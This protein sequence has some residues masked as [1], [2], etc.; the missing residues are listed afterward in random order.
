MRL[1]CHYRPSYSTP[2]S[3]SGEPFSMS[4]SSP[5]AQDQEKGLDRLPTELFL[6]CS[7]YMDR[8]DLACLMRTCRMFRDTLGDTIY[9]EHALP[10]E[11][12]YKE[13]CSHDSEGKTHGNKGNTSK[14]VFKMRDNF[15]MPYEPLAT[16]ISDGNYDLVRRFMK[17][18]VNPNAVSLNSISM[19]HIAIQEHRFEITQLMLDSGADPNIEC[20][21]TKQLALDFVTQRHK[22]AY[23]WVELL[24]TYGANFTRTET[25]EWLCKTGRE[26]F[27]R[28]AFNNGTDVVDLSDSMH[29]LRSWRLAQAMSF[30][31]LMM[32]ETLLDLEPRLTRINQYGDGLSLLHLALERHRP[33]VALMLIGRQFKI[34]TRKDPSF[35]RHVK[36]L[37]TRI[38]RALERNRDSDP[39][40]T[41][42]AE[43][44]LD[45]CDQEAWE[46]GFNQPDRCLSIRIW[47]S[48]DVSSLAL[49]ILEYSP[50]PYTELPVSSILHVHYLEEYLE[51]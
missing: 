41:K 27:I 46:S 10:S 38:A 8:N 6:L 37:Y 43:D 31:S 39:A 23:A 47:K 40:W 51:E 9:R 30:S 2:L 36:C 44:L 13:W 17:A 35:V 18:G 21:V 25:F 50:S 7:R 12:C 14:K 4:E 32:I 16:A 20:L 22:Q 26:D 34:F 1:S 28:R 33:D 42:N 45:I 24:L 29:I 49:D 5:E 11:D 19:L 48:F 15:E 3:L